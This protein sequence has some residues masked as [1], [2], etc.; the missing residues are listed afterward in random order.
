MAIITSGSLA[1]F[2]IKASGERRAAATTN[3]G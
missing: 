1:D 2:S 3:S